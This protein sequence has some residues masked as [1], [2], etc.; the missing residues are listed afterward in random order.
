M[1]H[2]IEYAGTQSDDIQPNDIYFN[3][4][5]N[6]DSQRKIKICCA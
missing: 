1:C 5:H 4:I 6:K 2:D 3:D